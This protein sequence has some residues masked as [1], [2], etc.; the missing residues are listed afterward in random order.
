[1]ILAIIN[2]M[3]AAAALLGT[4]FY[5]ILTSF[6]NNVLNTAA[7][8]GTRISTVLSAMKNK[9]ATVA[10]LL[11]TTLSFMFSSLKKLAHPRLS[12]LL[13]EPLEYAWEVGLTG[14]L[15]NT[16]FSLLQVALLRVF[17]YLAEIKV[18]LADLRNEHM[19]LNDR[20]KA[21]AEV[22]PASLHKISAL[23]QEKI[24][25]FQLSNKNTQD[26][27]KAIEAE[28]ASENRI[29]DQKTASEEHLQKRL[30][31]FEEAKV[32]DA[33]VLHDLRIA[34][35]EQFQ[36]TNEKLQN[37]L[38]ATVKAEAKL[39]A[40]KNTADEQLQ[41]IRTL[42]VEASKA[43][44]RFEKEKVAAEEN[45]MAL[46][47]TIEEQQLVLDNLTMEAS[48]A[49]SKFK[50][51]QGVANEA[52][53]A[54]QIQITIKQA[55]FDGLQNRRKSWEENLEKLNK[56][57]KNAK[58]TKKQLMDTISSEKAHLEFLQEL[59]IRPSE[60]YLQKLRG[61]INIAIE[62]LKLLQTTIK[63]EEA[64]LESATSHRAN[65]EVALEKVR[66]NIHQKM[67]AI[68]EIQAVR[69]RKPMATEVVNL[70]QDAVHLESAGTM[71]EEIKPE[72]DTTVNLESAG[73]TKESARVRKRRAEKARKATRNLKAS[74]TTQGV[75]KQDTTANMKSEGEM[76]E[77]VEVEKKS[78][79]RLSADHEVALWPYKIALN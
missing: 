3:L 48:A 75:E 30:N 45:L 38:K 26:K 22:E 9:M 49:N 36:I 7:L 28:V 39:M 10:I 71:T 66:A 59:R 8:V 41:E 58:A 55:N 47:Q 14:L 67:K 46:K 43:K 4:M 34:T 13:L 29:N 60:D 25:H 53:L 21:I 69:V 70:Q 42:K 54:L 56:E 65:A 52:L 6:Q 79:V 27:L 24:E 18:H 72:R 32:A 35:E 57:I 19:K 68:Q 64:T 77:D 62:R 76:K 2:Y 50:E 31:T 17:Q 51:E 78:A 20:I 40:L 16:L 11:G 23:N 33:K 63:K 15:G 73:N 5:D 37:Q 61:G 44:V 12:N 1:M 74:K